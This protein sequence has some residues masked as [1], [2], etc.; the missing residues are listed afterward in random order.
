MA[1]GPPAAPVTVVEIPVR[2]RCRK[3]ADSDDERD[4]D[5]TCHNEL[6]VP[7]AKPLA[8]VVLSFI[9]IMQTDGWLGLELRHLMALRAVAEEGSFGRAATRLG[10]TQSAISQQI[11]SLERIVGQQLLDRPGGPRP[12]SLTEAGTLLLRHANAITAR[13]SA[14]QADLSAFLD[15]DA[16]TLRV[17]TYQSVSAKLLP[18][19]LRDVHAASPQVEVQLR[20]SADDFEL[21]TL[22]EQGELDLAFVALPIRP[23]PFEIVELMRDPHVLLVQADSPLA[24]RDRPPTLRELAE[25]PLISWRNCRITKTIEERLHVGGREPRILF[26]S[27][28]NGTVQALVAAGHGVAIVPRLTVDFRDRSVALVDLGDRIP[29]RTIAIAWHADRV[30]TRAAGAFVEAAQKLCAGFEDRVTAAA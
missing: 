4:Y 2:Q 20:E 30:R 14:A 27:D 21:L 13:I 5:H 16:G 29:P 23:G 25:L 1:A 15:G 26:R 11:A 3:E 17:G 10:Y 6:I 12:V 28:D 22:V 7:S 8:Q 24:A 9:S 19:L 18:D